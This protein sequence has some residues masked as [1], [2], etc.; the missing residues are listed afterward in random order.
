M[1]GVGMKA[2]FIKTDSGEELAVLPRAD[3][4]DLLRQ[5]HGEDAGTARI[6]SRT[7]AALKARQDVELPAEVAEAIARGENPLRV[8]RQ[9]R[10]MIQTY[11][12]EVKTQI[13][14]STVSALENGTRRGTP[15]I[16]KKLAEVLRVPM[17]VLIP[18]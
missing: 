8:I 1:K 3:Y 5:A 11:L 18:D 16:W 17:D 4:E 10:D 15:A 12:G 13:G 9:W 14:Q 7:T 2:Q 6:I